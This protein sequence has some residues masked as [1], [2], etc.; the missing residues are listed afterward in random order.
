MVGSPGR[1]ILNSLSR[2]AQLHATIVLVVAIGYAFIFRAHG[3]PW[4]WT[5]VWI[6]GLSLSA[7]ATHRPECGLAAYA[8]ILYST[9]RY[10]QLFNRLFESNLLHVAVLFTMVGAALWMSKEGRSWRL[11]TPLVALASALF[12]WFCLSWLFADPDARGATAI[13]QNPR[14]SLGFLFDAFVMLGI[15]SQVMDRQGAGR[16]LILPLAVGLTIR[17]LWQGFDGLRLEGDIGPLLVM[18]LPL[19]LLLAEIDANWLVKL[20]MVAAALGVLPTVAVTYNRASAVAIGA[21]FVC[22]GWRYRRNIWILGATAVCIAAAAF[23]LTNSPYRGRFQEAW[24]ELKGV[25]V[26]SV[27]QRL[28]LWRAGFA[29]AI[30]HPVVGV[31]PG[32]YASE[33]RLYSTALHGTLVAH[34]NYVQVAA[35]TGF[36]GLALYLALFGTA[37]ASAARATGQS[38]HDWRGATA[39][40]LQ[41]SIVAYLVAGLFISRHDMVLAYMLVGWIAATASAATVERREVGSISR[42]EAADAV[43]S[44][45]RD[46]Q[47]RV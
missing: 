29:I 46:R 45:P 5:A 15:A 47:D 41:V 34:N 13:L 38:A 17:I 20:S 28:D 33:T 42:R 6:L 23:W 26:G 39:G 21:V 12:G 19:F 32:G 10:E 37:L 3:A 27:S 4:L 18:L 8:V 7:A 43:V 30:D 2:Q 24:R 22:L 1:P 36:P 44:R 11:T 16:W 40:A 14:H 25:E 9:P 35:E 31:G